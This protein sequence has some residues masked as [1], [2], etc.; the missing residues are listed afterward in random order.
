MA[1]AFAHPPSL[2][3]PISVD[4]AEAILEAI[5]GNTL[6]F[7]AQRS[8]TLFASSWRAGR[9]LTAEDLDR[10]TASIDRTV[11]RSID[12]MGEAIREITRERSREVATPG[13]QAVTERRGVGTVLEKG[14]T[15]ETAAYNRLANGME[16]VSRLLVTR[17]RE[18]AKADLAA[19]LGATGKVW[20]TRRDSRVRTSHGDL[21]GDFRLMNEPFVT[22][23]NAK[24][25]FPGDPRAPLSETINCRCRL[26][27]RMAP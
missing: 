10:V 12:S 5:V 17:T 23:R 20:R 21:E 26:S 22:I 15:T 16:S 1:E 25:Q 24:L 8:L 13:S 19:S 9:G 18:Q 2:R 6:R 14:L 7:Y 3:Y 4:R 11:P 27:Y